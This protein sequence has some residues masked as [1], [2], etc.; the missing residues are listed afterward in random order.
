MPKTAKTKSYAVYIEVFQILG[1]YSPDSEYV[2]SAE[3]D[4]IFLTCP[5]ER[6]SDEDRARLKVLGVG[7]DEKLD[8]FYMLT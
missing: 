4:I 2:I 6:V 1:R 3:H 5:V 8:S 7:F